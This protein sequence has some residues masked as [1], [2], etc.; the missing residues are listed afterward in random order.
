MSYQDNEFSQLKGKE[1]KLIEW[2]GMKRK[3]ALF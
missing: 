1:V 3:L 2:N